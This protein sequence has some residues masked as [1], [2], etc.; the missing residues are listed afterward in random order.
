MS[1]L[2]WLFLILYTL[3]YLFG[4]YKSSFRPNATK[5]YLTVCFDTFYDYNVTFTLLWIQMSLHFWLLHFGLNLFSFKSAN[6]HS[7]SLF[8]N[9]FF[10]PEFY[11][12]LFFNTSLFLISAWFYFLMSVMPYQRPH[13]HCNLFWFHSTFDAFTFCESLVIDNS[14]YKSV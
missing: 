13:S 6:S 1:L 3:N 8:G 4:N 9:I 12:I 10:C 7:N 11:F 14:F 5:K 2:F